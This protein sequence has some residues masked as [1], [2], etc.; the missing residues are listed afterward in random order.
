[1][2]RMEMHINLWKS[3]SPSPK[4]IT[5]W[6]ILPKAAVVSMPEDRV[7]AMPHPVPKLRCL[8]RCPAKFLLHWSKNSQNSLSRTQ[9][10][11]ERQEEITIAI[12]ADLLQSNRRKHQVKK[13][14]LRNLKRSS[15]KCIRVRIG[16]WLN[17]WKGNWWSV[18]PSGLMILLIWRQLR[19]CY[20]KLCYFPDL[21]RNSSKE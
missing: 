6:R 5:I 15:Q 21:C 1:M 16:D 8:W 18:P 17:S 11:Q 19:I 14:R 9:I 20:R 13:T 12:Q 10:N 4:A 2:T 3:G 7:L